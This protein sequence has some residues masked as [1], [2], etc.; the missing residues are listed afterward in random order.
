MVEKHIQIKC[1]SSLIENIFQAYYDA[2]KNK[3]NSNSSLGF[4]LEYEKNLVKLFWEISERRYVPSPHS[5]FIIDKPVKREVFASEFRD[6]IVHHLIFNYI[7]PIF[8]PLFIN[9]SYSC[10]INKGTLYGVKRADYFIKSCSENYKKDAYI[11]KLDIEG[12]FMSIDRTLLFGIIK[13]QVIKRQDKLTCELDLIL[14]LLEKVIFCDP[15]E[16]CLVKSDREAWQGLPRSKSLFFSKPGKGLPIGN[17]TSQLF[18]NI[19]LNEID[20]F[21]KRELKFKYY[22]RY[23]DDMIFVDNDKERLLSA[24]SDIREYLA[25]SLSLKLHPKK[26]YLQHYSKGVNFLGAYIKPH[27]ILAG[28]RMRRNFYSRVY[29]EMF[30]LGGMDLAAENRKEIDMGIVKFRQLANSY[31][32]ILGQF[33]SYVIRKGVVELVIDNFKMTFAADEDFGVL[34]LR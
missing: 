33:D 22:G 20:Q 10:R 31:L 14:Y 25:D 32:G 24:I 12:Y 15:T 21:V 5:A 13:K 9:D 23:V 4:E 7:N 18:A 30:V 6:R 3:R 19:Y 29:E 17:L 26:I 8:D 16:G 1:G 34:R 28:K 2:R 11:M 27:R